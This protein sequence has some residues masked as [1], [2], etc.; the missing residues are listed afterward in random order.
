MILG[1]LRIFLGR[2][3][4]ITG[5]LRVKTPLFHVLV[6]LI[7]FFLIFLHFIWRIQTN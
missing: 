4:R 6:G 2:R 3:Y 5:R 7:S 1:S